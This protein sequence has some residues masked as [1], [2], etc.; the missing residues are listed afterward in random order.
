MAKTILGMTFPDT[1]N[2][3]D[4]GSMKMDKTNE[5]LHLCSVD[6]DKLNTIL[7]KSVCVAEYSADEFSFDSGDVAIVDD[8]QRAFVYND[9]LDFWTEWDI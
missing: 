8:T 1:N 3:P 4:F 7:T 5:Y 9:Y 2:I 6:V